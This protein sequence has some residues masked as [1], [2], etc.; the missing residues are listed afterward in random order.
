M[1]PLVLRQ[2]DLTTRWSSIAPTPGSLASERLPLPLAQRS[3]WVRP[4]SLAAAFCAAARRLGV[5]QS[6]VAWNDPY[7]SSWARL[8]QQEPAYLFAE[9][10]SFSPADAGFVFSEAQERDP[11]LAAHLIGDLARDLQGWIRRM[12]FD[13]PGLF[14]KQLEQLDTEIRLRERLGILAVMRGSRILDM[15][16]QQ[17]LASDPNPQGHSL[18][19]ARGLREQLRAMHTML[20]N[21]AATFQPRA[22]AAFDRRIE[23]RQ[24]DPALGLL[25]AELRAAQHVEAALN[26]LPERHT[27]HYYDAIIGQQPSPRGPSASCWRSIQARNRSFWHGAPSLRRAC[28]TAVS[29]NSPAR[30]G[31]RSAPRMSVT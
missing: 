22:Q 25:V 26:R 12:E 13:V 24:M 19:V 11:K 16:R 29:R 30:A 5:T 28:P 23:S 10:I 8:F 7:A 20:R 17:A 1:R 2:G 4:Q 3:L 27:R 21:A 14:T 18:K 31:F 6:E 15:L 9:L